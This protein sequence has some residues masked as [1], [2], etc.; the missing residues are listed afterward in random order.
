MSRSLE[1]LDPQIRRFIE[2]VCREGARLRG[3]SQPGWPQR[4]VIAAQARAPWREGGPRMRDI[5]DVRLA[6]AHGEFGVRILHPQ[7]G[8]ATPSPALVYLHGGGWCLFGLDTHDRLLRE[9]AD[10]MR[11]PVVAIDY[12]LAPEHPYPAAL[13]QAVATLDWLQAH[14]AAF[15]IDAT[16]LALG[17]DSAGANLAVATALRLRERGELARIRTLLLN[18]GA[19][20]PAL[21][22]TARQTLGTS[23]D[24]LSGAE[25]DEFWEAYLGPDAARVAGPY[26]APLLAEL[27]DLPPALM[28]WG[29]RDVLAEQN[30]DMAQAL[31]A[32][33]VPVRTQVHAGAPHSFIEAMAVSEQAREA[34]ARG[35]AW[36]RDHLSSPPPG[37]AA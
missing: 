19:W 37:H 28:L 29:D 18:Y 30:A 13:D 33:G 11:L 36:V 32:A 10:A 1:A 27:R 3:D 6:S 26:S 35:A 34:V 23:E 12:S 17:G 2:E 15:G 5:A 24:M 25:M 7:A 8:A 22:D 16:Q 31:I 14:G 21:S 9:Y 20:A 4:R